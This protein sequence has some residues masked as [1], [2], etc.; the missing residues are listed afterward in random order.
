MAWYNP[1]TWS[2][3]TGVDLTEEQKRAEELNQWRAELDRRAIEEGKWDDAAQRQV[4]IN[5]QAE[6]AGGYDG[7]YDQQVSQAAAD[8]AKEGL[9][10]MQSGVKDTLTAATNTVLGGVLGFVPWWLWLVGLAAGAWY[11]GLFKG[12]LAR[13]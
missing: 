5:R 7:N 2:L 6:S 10:N 13:K 3:F 8:G 11:L 9:A 12:V 1:A 4:E